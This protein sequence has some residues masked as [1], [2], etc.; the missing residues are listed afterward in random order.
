MM[1]KERIGN[2]LYVYR[3]GSLLYKR[4]LALGYGKVFYAVAL[5]LL[6]SCTTPR[7]VASETAQN[8]IQPCTRNARAAEP[9]PSRIK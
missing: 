2:E 3:N 1:W 9:T 8:G 4:W 5:I 6:A 7:T